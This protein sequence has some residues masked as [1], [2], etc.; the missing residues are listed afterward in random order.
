MH[1][2]QLGAIAVEPAETFQPNH[3]SRLSRRANLKVLKSREDPVVWQ[4]MLISN[5]SQCSI[6]ADVGPR[7][8][9]VKP[10]RFDVQAGT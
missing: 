2:N 5:L 8:L 10:H 1:K 6:K 4:R 9:N 7:V 3:V